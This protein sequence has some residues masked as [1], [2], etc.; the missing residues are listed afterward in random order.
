MPPKDPHDWMWAEAL[1]ML[2]RTERMHRQ[3]FQPVVGPNLPAWEPPVDLLETPE[4][5]LIIAALPGVPDDH[6]EVAIEG[7]QLVVRGERPPP[8]EMARVARIH[9]M[10][11]PQGRFERRVPLPPGRYDAAH[12]QL[13]DGCLFVS[14]RKI[15]P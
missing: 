8:A 10:E 14:L 3:L 9:R 15:T 7:A 13:T 1:D 12:R 2:A 6:V 5:V 11:L 4:E